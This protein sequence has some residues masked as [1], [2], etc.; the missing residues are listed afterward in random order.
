MDGTVLLVLIQHEFRQK[1]SN[2][3]PPFTQDQSAV[4]PESDNKCDFP[5]TGKLGNV[6]LDMF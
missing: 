2:I 4:M 3:T 5:R 1:V 6:K